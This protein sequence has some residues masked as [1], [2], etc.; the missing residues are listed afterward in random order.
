MTLKAD[1]LACKQ[2]SSESVEKFAYRLREKAVI[3]FSS[4]DQAN[5]NCLIAFV[6]GVRDPYIGR[7]LNEEEF[8]DFNEAVKL[9]K[10]LQAIDRLYGEKEAVNVSTLKETHLS[11]T[12]KQ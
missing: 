7:K 4:E 8:H 5:Q 6:K 11:F 10:R 9:D 3:P 12:Q 1:V 2:L